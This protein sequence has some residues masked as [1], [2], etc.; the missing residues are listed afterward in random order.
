MSVPDRVDKRVPDERQQV[1]ELAD[2]APPVSEPSGVPRDDG[3]DVLLV[4]EVMDVDDE[5]GVPVP[6]D[7]DESGL[8]EPRQPRRSVRA[9]QLDDRLT[10]DEAF[11]P[12][13]RCDRGGGV[14]EGGGGVDGRLG[15]RVGTT[16]GP[17]CTRPHS[18]HAWSVAATGIR[19]GRV[20]GWKLV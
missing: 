19:A 5:I 20:H 4:H 3:V 14:P 11:I 17:S 2:E 13:D 9:V 8:D 7:L 15:L 10:R 18:S 16:P 1:E 6:G 12:D